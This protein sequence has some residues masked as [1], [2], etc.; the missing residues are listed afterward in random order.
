MSTTRRR[1]SRRDR[2]ERGDSTASDSHPAQ[3][4]SA[5]PP[6]PNWKWRTFPVYFAFSL[7]IF[8]G[9]YLGILGAAMQDEG[10]GWFLT[11]AFIGVAVMLGLGFSRLSTRWLM[12]RNWI[13]PRS[14]RKAK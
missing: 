4:G 11:A 10:E 7:G 9:L 12:D 1:R 5:R 3:P 13:K 8:I 14:V 2:G 6:G